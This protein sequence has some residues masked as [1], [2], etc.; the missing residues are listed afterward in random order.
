MVQA[1]QLLIGP[2]DPREPHPYSIQQTSAGAAV[3]P[4]ATLTDSAGYPAGHPLFLSRARRGS[5]SAMG[6][7][8]GPEGSLTTSLESTGGPQSHPFKTIQSDGIPVTLISPREASQ[9]R[10]CICPNVLMGRRTVLGLPSHHRS[11]E[12]IYP[13]RPGMH[14][15]NRAQMQWPS[16][17]HH[18]PPNPSVPDTQPRPGSQGSRADPLPASPGAGATRVTARGCARVT[19]PSHPR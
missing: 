15:I 10:A 16:G 12:R 8:K 6:G 11:P 2:R 19:S 3:G 18:I 1:G 14:R 4:H 7:Q 5:A 17:T 13:G 9:G